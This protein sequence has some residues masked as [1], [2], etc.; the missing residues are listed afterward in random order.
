MDV[1]KERR[2]VANSGRSLPLVVTG[3]SH[4]ANASGMSTAIAASL[5]PCKHTT[6]HTTQHR[7]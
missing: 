2:E 6:P 7:L 3:N 4:N 5:Q 1:T